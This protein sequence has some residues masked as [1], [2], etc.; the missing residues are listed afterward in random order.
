MNVKNIELD[1]DNF[2]ELV[3]DALDIYS[4]QVPFSREYEKDL[5]GSRN[6][7]LDETF[8]PELGRKPEWLSEVH[9]IRTTGTFYGHYLNSH[10][11]SGYGSQY[12][13]TELSE[14]TI[15]PWK[16]NKESGKLTVPYSGFYKIVGV[17]RHTIEKTQ[18]DSGN[19]TWTVNTIGN[20]DQ[21]FIKLCQAMFM[22]GIGRSRRAFTLQ[23]LPILMD[24]AEIVSEGRELY[25]EVIDEELPKYQ[26][27]HLAYGG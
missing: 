27:F 25:K 1:V 16:Y 10:N 11:R 26:K 18:D 4:D 5:T 21:A 17:Y 14:P 2:R 19:M 6:L 9:P 12:S 13:T 24:A 15:A 8:D 3:E 7:T 23:D 22:I 20:R